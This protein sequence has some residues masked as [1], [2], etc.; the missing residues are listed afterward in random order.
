MVT[1]THNTV[2]DTPVSVTRITKQ[3]WTETGHRLINYNGKCAHLHGHSYLWEVNAERHDSG[4]SEQ[5]FV[6][7]FKDLKAYMTKAID[8]KYDH[9]L[10]LCRKDPLL[11][12]ISGADF[13]VPNL[14]QVALVYAALRGSDGSEG[15]LVFVDENPSAENLARWVANDLQN[16]IDRDAAARRRAFDISAATT[17]P[18]GYLLITRVR[19]WETRSSYVDYYP[20]GSSVNG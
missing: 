11:A 19:L 4:V 15:R 18:P 20:P 12:Y 10:V 7:D 5:G 2:E 3:M 6:V 17:P 1:V 14:K 9:A 16:H 8:E 13:E